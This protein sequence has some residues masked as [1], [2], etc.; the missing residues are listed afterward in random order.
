MLAVN[1][2]EVSPA[3]TLTVE[4]TVT[5]DWLLLRVTVAPPCGAG[6]ERVTVPVEDDP[7][8]TLVGFRLSLA[9]VSGLIVSGTPMDVEPTLAVTLAVVFDVTA[10]V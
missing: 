7:P 2:P 6:P 10:N 1:E 3:E 5:V 8:L 9:T 4:G